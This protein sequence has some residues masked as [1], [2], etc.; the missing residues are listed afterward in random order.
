MQWAP[1]RVFKKEY[2]DTE[3]KEITN[4]INGLFPNVDSDIFPVFL[5]LLFSQNDIKRTLER[6]VNFYMLGPM[7]TYSG[8][9]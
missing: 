3:E 7:V 2:S 9:I 5:M 8:S 1:E 4:L 6:K